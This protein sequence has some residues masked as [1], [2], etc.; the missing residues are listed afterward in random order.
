MSWKWNLPVLPTLVFALFVTASVAYGQAPAAPSA[1][2]AEESAA[3]EIPAVPDQGTPEEYLQYIEKLLNQPLPNA[4][5]E[6]QKLAKALVAAADKVLEQK[7]NVEETDQALQWK[8]R[9]L[10]LQAQ[11]G[12]MNAVLG[13]RSMGDVL[14]AKAEEVFNNKPSAE[15]AATAG[16]WILLALRMGGDKYTAKVDAIIKKLEDGGL[17]ELASQL[18]TSVL[19][20]KLQSADPEQAK[21]LLAEAFAMLDSMAESM[22]TPSA[23]SRDNVT[24]VLNV[25]QTLERLVDD[26]A[27]IGSYYEKFGKLFAGAEDEQIKGLGERLSGVARRLQLIGNKMELAG[28]TLDGEDFDWDSYRG[29]VVLV[30]FFASWCGPCRAEMPNVKKNYELYHDKGFEVVGI[31]VDRSREDL[32]KYLADNPVP[33]KIIFNEDPNAVGPANPGDYYGILAIPTVMLVDKDGKVI[34]FEARGEALSAK[35]AEIFGPAEDDSADKSDASQGE[36]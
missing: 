17:G 6:R 33:W 36:G 5:S 12:D 25:L 1:P 3:T 30:D 8:Y 31:S 20:A 15:Q 2:G 13:L 26:Q 29:K 4:P 21:A 28:K 34:T 35:L 23:V 32:E 14:V 9:G 19:L 16:D 18:K 24:T 7:A 10:I 27:K 11:S 22:S